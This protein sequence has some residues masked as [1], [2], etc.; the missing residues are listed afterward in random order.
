M[1]LVAIMFLFT[2]VCLFGYLFHWKTRKL[3]AH[4]SPYICLLI[5]ALLASHLHGAEANPAILAFGL[6]YLF[7]HVVVAVNNNR[8]S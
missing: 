2:G 8:G 5:A 1:E 7:L 6:L 3:V 4:L